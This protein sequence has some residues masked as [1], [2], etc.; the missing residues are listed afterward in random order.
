MEKRVNPKNLKKGILG[1][2]G[3]KL[4]FFLFLGVL[5]ISGV[6]YLRYNS[7]KA[8]TYLDVLLPTAET[9][10]TVYS[11]IKNDGSIYY[12]GKNTGKH[13]NIVGD[14][15]ELRVPVVD[16]PGNYLTSLKVILK[17]P[18]NSA[19]KTEHEILAIHGVNS[20]Y[21]TVQDQSTILYEANGVS[22]Y[23]AVSIVAKIPQGV[24][25]RPFYINMVGDLTQVEFNYWVALAATLPLLT[26]IY[27]VL[28]LAFQS[29]IHRVDQPSQP[30]NYPPMAI[31]PAIVGALYHEAVGPR[32]I[33]AT[34]VDLARRK[35]I[36]IL[37]RERGFAFGKGHFD[38]RLLGYEKILLSKIFRQSITAERAEVEKRISNHLYSKKISLVLA[39]IYNIATQMGYFRANPSKVHAKYRLIGIFAFLIGAAGFF[40]SFV[41]NFLPRFTSLFWV[42]MMLS[43]LIIAATAS[44]IPLR[45]Q[46]GNEALSNWLAFRRF[47]S[48][49][50]PIPYSNEIQAVF[51][52]YLPYA[53][54]LDCE[55]AWSKRFEAHNFVV[56]D[57]YL[58]EKSGLSLQDF[59]LSLFPIVSYIGR[60]FASIREPGFE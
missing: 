21:S 37:D 27:M 30:V 56:P 46:L 4:I 34:L 53:I 25:D 20:A 41:T 23:G 48:D 42:G 1:I 15:D 31:P 18:R 38:S 49:P 22:S 51:E 54:V 59:C 19:A 14:Y 32:E 55:A 43:A 3:R 40:V 58:T 45:S 5:A 39:G 29:K 26:I 33:A 13:L 2:Y 50:K 57:W 36:V 6:F 35:N 44:R 28:F 16:R 11:E 52:A 8:D 24:I 47:L 9:N 12:N 7:Y 17:V 10:P 60:S